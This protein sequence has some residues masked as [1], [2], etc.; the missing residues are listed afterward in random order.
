MDAARISQLRELHDEDRR[1][2]TLS[3][4]AQCR[5]DALK[6]AMAKKWQGPAGAARWL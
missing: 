4:Q 3:S 1:L 6:E 2:K 5:A